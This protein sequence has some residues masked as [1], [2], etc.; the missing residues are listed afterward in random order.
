MLLS[1]G[2]KVNSKNKK[3]EKDREENKCV[4]SVGQIKVRARMSVASCLYTWAKYYLKQGK[5]LSELQ[6]ILV[7][8]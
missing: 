1:T 2:Q 4:L 5:K 3:S 6:R 7:F 8:F